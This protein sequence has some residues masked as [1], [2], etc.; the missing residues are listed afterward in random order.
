[1]SDG[2]RASRRRLTTRIAALR[3]FSSRDR[4]TLAQA[5]F[6]VMAI[7]LALRVVSL[8][9]V[10]A[11]LRRLA[12]GVDPHRHSSAAGDATRP[13]EIARLVSTASRHTPLANSC[14]HRSLALWWM[15]GRRGFG[16]TLQFGARKRDGVFEAHAWVERAGRVISEDAR[17]LDY[18]PMPWEPAEHD[19]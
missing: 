5:A 18:A 2:E 12:P 11:V 4:W 8:R 10:H 14:L 16:S 1:V 17:D 13:L 9:R 6:A 19:A 3:A 15:L 7:G